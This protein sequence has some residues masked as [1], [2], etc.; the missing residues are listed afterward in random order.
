MQS[1]SNAQYYPAV[2]SQ[3]NVACSET[4]SNCSVARPDLRHT[5]FVS[6]HPPTGSWALGSCVNSTH[7]RQLRSTTSSRHLSSAFPPNTID[8]DSHYSSGCTRAMFR[9]QTNAFDDAVFK[10]T[11]E[12]LTSEN[13]EYILVRTIPDTHELRRGL[14][15]A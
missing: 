10:A 14:P 1:I 9:A 13:W 8:R 15:D 11:D 6:D 5:S 12:N 7:F 2:W 3:A 4:S